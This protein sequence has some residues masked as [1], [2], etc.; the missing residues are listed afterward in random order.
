MQR[1]SDSSPT[2]RPGE[3]SLSRRGLLL[4]GLAG[5]GALAGC[6]SPGSPSGDRSSIS[7][8]PSPPPAPTP[9]PTPVIPRPFPP[10]SDAPAYVLVPGEVEP[11]CKQAAVDFLTAVLTTGTVATAEVPL[12]ARLAALGQSAAVAAPLLPLLPQDG[13]SSVE[14]VYPQY[15]GLSP[16]RLDA[17]IM[18]V[19]DHLV[20]PADAVRPVTSR[21]STTVDLRLSRRTGPWVV[22]EVLPAVLPPLAV[23]PS[24]TALALLAN[25]R[26]VLPAAARADVFGDGVH[27]AVLAALNALSQRWQVHVQVLTAGHPLNIFATSQISNHTL[28][29]A[30]DIWALDGVPVIDRARCPWRDLMLASLDLGAG[31]VGGPEEVGDRRV[32]TNATHQDHV[33]VGFPQAR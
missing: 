6:H 31:E 20:R 27:D 5:V 19:A 12:D 30:V 18:L 29:K 9:S 28:G 7:P 22:T 13:A 10:L 4:G 21:R 15:G 2:T 26:V 8:S 3:R 24:P 16:D 17:S 23:A 25:D 32:F 11:A 1:L 14:V 33:H